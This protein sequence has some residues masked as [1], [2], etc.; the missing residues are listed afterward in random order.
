MRVWR[1][2]E[3]WRD[4]TVSRLARQRGLRKAVARMQLAELSSAFDAWLS[5]TEESKRMRLV[6]RR[7]MKRMEDAAAGDM[8]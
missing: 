4:W 6:A 3:S 5:H 8:G 2:L 1:A 7:V